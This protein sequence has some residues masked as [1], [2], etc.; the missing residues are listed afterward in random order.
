[1]KLTIVRGRDSEDVLV[2][3]SCGDLP[4]HGSEIRGRLGKKCAATGEVRE[5]AQNL[6]RL[7]EHGR[8]AGG[9]KFVVFGFLGGHSQR[10]AESHGK[11]HNIARA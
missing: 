8:F 5:R 4:V 9:G 2:T 10:G 11:D 6:V 1:M 3:E 7:G